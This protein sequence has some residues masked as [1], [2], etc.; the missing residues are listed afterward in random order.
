[1]KSKGLVEP[2]EA[3]PQKAIQPEVASKSRHEQSPAI[4][5][6]IDVFQAHH[7]EADWWWRKP[8][9]S[10]AGLPDG[11]TFLFR[12]IFNDAAYCYELK[13]RRNSTK[14][15]PPTYPLGKPFYKLSP[16]EALSVLKKVEKINRAG[17]HVAPLDWASELSQSLPGVQ[18]L[19]QIDLKSY[20]DEHL[21]SQFKR[22]LQRIR[23]ESGIPE[24]SE[25]AP[26]SNRTLNTGRSFR[27]IEALDVHRLSDDGVLRKHYSDQVNE[28]RKDLRAMGRDF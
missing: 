22:Q 28:A 9:V 27:P 5:E 4:L 10:M 20:R 8:L 23:S 6:R 17:L 19:L 3:E 21:C 2:L 18:M 25:S 16:D 26:T 13:A 11:D 7:S 14:G 12:Q 15:T 1:M 24:P